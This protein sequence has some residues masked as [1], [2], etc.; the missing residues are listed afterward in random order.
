MGQPA[1]RLTDMTMCPMVNPGTPPVPHVGGPITGPCSPNVIIDDLLAA[2]MTDI[3]QCVAPP[4][5][6]AKGFAT[7]YINGLQAARVLD[8]TSRGGQ[9]ATG[10]PTVLIGG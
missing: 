2:R 3:A 6:I 4:D 10:F 9:I 5:A 8:L 1:A 7:L